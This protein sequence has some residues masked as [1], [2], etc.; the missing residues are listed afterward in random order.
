MRS[1][2]AARRAAEREANRLE[3]IPFE[4]SYED[5][6]G[7]EHEE[8]F[9]L[10]GEVSGATLT[11]L[12]YFADTPIESPEGAAVVRRVFMEAFGDEVEFKRF[13]R[14]ATL[15]DEDTLTDIMVG[16]IEDTTGRPTR[17]PS[18]SSARS[19]TTGQ[20]SRAV[21]L[22]EASTPGDYFTD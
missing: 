2:K 22:P 17:R 20:P 10:C 8:T 9:H 18:D 21:S 7:E 19:S 14:V 3:P 15:L 12:G 5:A 13:W 4:V 6:T 11:D 16:A 1:Y